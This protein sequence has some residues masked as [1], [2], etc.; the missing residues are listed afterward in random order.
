VSQENV[1]I[2]RAS[3]DAF[4]R[5]E[6]DVAG[7]DWDDDAVV[8][9]S[10]SEGVDAGVYRGRRAFRAFWAGWLEMFDEF[11]F[12][13]DEFIERGEHVVMPNLTRLRG[14]DGMEVEAHS[15]VIATVR[16]GRVVGWRLYRNR[17]EALKAVGL[18]E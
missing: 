14:R 5:R 6:L 15:V 8:D 11:H 12:E 9:W 10:R 18:E 13:V 17:G 7:R 4:T 16:D 2:V 1:E 3:I